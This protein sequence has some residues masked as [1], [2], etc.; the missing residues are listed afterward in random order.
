MIGTGDKHISG[1]AVGTDTF[2]KGS[3]FGA[4][5]SFSLTRLPVSVHAKF[6]HT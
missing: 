6:R 1:V 3:R 2:G 4:A 5:L